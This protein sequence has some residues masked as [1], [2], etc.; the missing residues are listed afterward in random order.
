MPPRR[1]GGFVLTG[2]NAMRRYRSPGSRFDPIMSTV[3][4][5][6]PINDGK[7]F[8][9]EDQ[10]LYVPSEFRLMLRFT[11][12]TGIEV[13]GCSPGSFGRQKLELNDL[14]SNSGV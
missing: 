5:R 9:E 3:R 14:L 2:L 8:L 6:M 4:W 10:R 1:I 13:Y 11:G 12:F 7:E